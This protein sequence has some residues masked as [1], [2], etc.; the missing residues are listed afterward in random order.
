ML[1]DSI[2]VAAVEIDS[3][4]FSDWYESRGVARATAFRLLKLARIERRTGKVP[5]SRVPIRVL[6]LQQ[7]AALDRLVARLRDGS[8][9]PQLEA[10]ITA[11]LVAT[12]SPAETVS[13]DL[14]H[15][16]APFDHAAL[17]ARLEAGERAIRTGLPL[18]TAEV[19]WLLQA[20]PGGDRVVRAGVEA[21]RHGRNCWEIRP[22]EAV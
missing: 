2:A 5:G 21:V 1:S 15:H 8:T 10:E 16:P 18:S 17:L 4:P 3:L 22:S 7:V 14:S 13:D 12:S 6:D 20:R 11:A 9:M 19:G